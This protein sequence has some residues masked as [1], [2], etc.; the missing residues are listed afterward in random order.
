MKGEI[1]Y[2]GLLQQQP[3]EDILNKE[4]MRSERIK[5]VK[6]M[7]KNYMNA[8]KKDKGFILDSLIRI[9]GYSRKYAS[10]LLIKSTQTVKLNGSGFILKAD[11]GK[12]SSRKRAKI[13]GEEVQRILLFLWRTFDYP[14]SQRLQA[15]LPYQLQKMEQ[16]WTLHASDWK[17]RA[18]NLNGDI[19]ALLLNMSRST[20][21]RI[22]GVERRKYQLK[23]ISHTKPGSLLKH[24]IPIRTFAEWNEHQ[25]LRLFTNYFLPGMQLQ[26]KLRIGAQVKKRYDT[27]RTPFQRVL[28]SPIVSI[29]DKEALMKTYEHLNP[30]ELKRKIKYLQTRLREIR[31]KKELDVLTCEDKLKPTNFRKEKLDEEMNET[32]HPHF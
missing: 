23:G 2:K 5:L 7:S 25:Q 19:K 12:R 22:L 6:I 28:E 27:P 3:Q 1:Q 14:C 10:A 11:P 26:E 29:Q 16:F 9:T 30:F 8:N 18:I 20:I 15:M 24:Q 21:E 4:L 31:R 32:F 13:Y 17:D